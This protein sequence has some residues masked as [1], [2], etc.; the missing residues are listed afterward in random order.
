MEYNIHVHGTTHGTE[1]IYWFPRLQR[2]ILKWAGITR[3][4][5]HTHPFSQV[6]AS[7]V[8]MEKFCLH[9]LSACRM[10]TYTEYYNNTEYY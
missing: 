3:Q 5:P 6:N 4:D 9:N 7:G 10:F 8:T 1:D 2:K